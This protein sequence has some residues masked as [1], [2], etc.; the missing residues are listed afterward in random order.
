MPRPEEPISSGGRGRH[1]GNASF[2]GFGT[3][4]STFDG[5]Q[6]GIS[7]TSKD[8][9]LSALPLRVIQRTMW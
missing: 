9:V 2:A 7:P 3:A 1:A 6:N 5:G 4:L 8:A